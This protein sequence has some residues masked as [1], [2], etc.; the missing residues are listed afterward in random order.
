M[1]TK[2]NKAAIIVVIIIVGFLIF[3]AFWGFD[4]IKARMEVISNTSTQNQE[5]NT[6]Q[7]L[8]YANYDFSPR[9][10]DEYGFDPKV[11]P[12]YGNPDAP[13]TVIEFTN[14]YCSFCAIFHKED[15]ARLLDKY[16]SDIYYASIYVFSDA[17]N[18]TDLTVA[19]ACSAQQGNN[20]FVE[21]GYNLNSNKYSE[22]DLFEQAE[23]L[24]LNMDEFSACYQDK[25][26]RDLLDK[27]ES[28]A[29]N[30]GVYSTPFFLIDGQM[31]I[32]ASYDYM[33]SAIAQSLEK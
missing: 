30:L 11:V 8:N 17:Y 6:F 13:V 2:K 18:N 7:A 10:T 23:V 16:Q 29:R 24:G 22:D 12:T 26:I 33:D 31:L 14:F 28:I 25:T 15:F 19:T 1:E 9:I 4:L 3:M 5:N 27:N 32:G 21:Y 20:G